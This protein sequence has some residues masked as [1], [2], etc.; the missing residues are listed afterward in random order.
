MNEFEILFPEIYLYAS[1]P[2]GQSKRTGLRYDCRRW[3]RDAHALCGI[4]STDR[5]WQNHFLRGLT[6]STRLVIF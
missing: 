6:L 5:R 3:V 1:N 2:T 4:P